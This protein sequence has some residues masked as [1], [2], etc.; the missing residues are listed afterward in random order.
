MFIAIHTLKH[1]N[2]SALNRGEDG[3]PKSVTF[4]GT[5]RGRISS[6]S[7]KRALRKSD[8]F[9]GFAKKDQLSIRTR[10]LPTL[11]VEELERLGWPGDKEEVLK[12]MSNIAKTEEKDMKEAGRTNQVIL[13]PATAPKQMAKEI[14]ALWAEGQKDLEANLTPANMRTVDVALWGAM[15]TSRLFPNVMAAT[16]VAHALSVNQNRKNID[17]FVAVD[18]ISGDARMLGEAPF[19]ANCYYHSLLVDV[20]QLKT[21]L[22]SDALLA[23]QVIAA[24]VKAVAFVSPRGK[25]NTMASHPLPDL[26][27]VE[28]LDGPFVDYANAFATPVEAAQQ[29]LPVAALDALKGYIEKTDQ[30]FDRQ[31]TR[32]Y[33]ATAPF[34]AKTACSSLNSLIQATEACC[35]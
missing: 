5:W 28:V 22:G 15:S 29:S 8:A 25:Q 20:E 26:L 16:Q 30:L 33:V 21:N 6:Q 27:M 34:L 32:F 7:L 17:Y 14:I 19:N 11:I 3:A 2:V 10:S 18:D 24:L 1:F 23:R 9:Q 31:P 35:A 12:I 13:L 4:G